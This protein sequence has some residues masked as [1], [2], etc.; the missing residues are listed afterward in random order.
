MAEIGFVGIRAV[1]RPLPPNASCVPWASFTPMLAMHTRLLN[2]RSRTRVAQM[3]GTHQALGASLLYG[4]GCPVCRGR[5]CTDMFDKLVRQMRGELRHPGEKRISFYRRRAGAAQRMYRANHRHPSLGQLLSR[6]PWVAGHAARDVDS[7]AGVVFGWRGTL[8][9]RTMPL[10]ADGRGIDQRRHAVENW[11]G[12]PQ[13]C[14]TSSSADGAEQHPTCRHT[15]R[16]SLAHGR[17][18]QRWLSE[19]LRRLCTD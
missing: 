4:T 9:W 5:P 18:A 11:A 10:G 7:V 3:L 1:G 15:R 19:N 17:G 6:Y 13:A 2:Y 16:E 14:L 8:L 12:S